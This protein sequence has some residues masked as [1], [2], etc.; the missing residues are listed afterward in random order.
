[1]PTPRYVSCTAD[2]VMGMPQASLISLK[3]THS[4]AV[5]ATEAT[6]VSHHS[7][8]LGNLQFEAWESLLYC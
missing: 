7:K 5:G 2:L 6:I 8:P 4:L 1:M 3:I